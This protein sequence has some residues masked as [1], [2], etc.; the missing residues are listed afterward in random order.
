MTQRDPESNPWQL[1][2]GPRPLPGPLCRGEGGG[3]AC[4]ARWGSDF[5]GGPSHLHPGALV[6]DAEVSTVGAGAGGE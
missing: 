2:P 1:Q 3:L 4:R 5:F 6:F